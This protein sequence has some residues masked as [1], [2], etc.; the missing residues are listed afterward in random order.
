MN[1]LE[2]SSANNEEEQKDRPFQGKLVF[3][4]NTLIFQDQ[5]LQDQFIALRN[6]S[7]SKTYTWVP[8]KKISGFKY[9]LS[10]LLTLVG[11]IGAFVFP[12]FILLA[13]YYGPIVYRGYKERKKPTLY[14]LSLGLNNGERFFF[15]SKDKPGIDKLHRFVREA[16][17]SEEPLNQVF[18]FSGDTITNYGDNNTTLTNPSTRGNMNIYPY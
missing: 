17:N 6:V 4:R 1:P 5:Q 11:V 7:A 9:V 18:N 3:E 16:I 12:L 10:I 8:K 14:G 13:I 15:S 2:N